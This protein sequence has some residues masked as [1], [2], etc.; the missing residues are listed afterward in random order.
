MFENVS[1][2]QLRALLDGLREGSIAAPL[3]TPRLLALGFT[4]LVKHQAQLVHFTTESL[5]L[6]CDAILA[7]RQKKQQSAELVWT[8][9]E[10]RAATARSTFVVFRD[11]LASAQRSVW[12]A[13]Y[14]VDH[15]KELFAPLHQAMLHRGVKVTFLLNLDAKVSRIEAVAE[16]ATELIN[17]FRTDNW[18]F[19][20][21]RPRFFYDPRSLQARAFASMH[22]K[23]LVVDEAHT[24]IGSANFTNRGQSRNI[25]AGALIHDTG[26]AKTLITQ[27]QSL[28]DS[29]YVQPYDSI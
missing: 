24:L 5:C 14:A 28:I 27:F 3:S 11:L 10:G 2:P 13:G 22:A 8:G 7:E 18:P 6:L 9:P 29:G 19:D 23:T 1:T 20:G 26:F 21:P 25:E 17:R 12:M 16:K 15:G 4:S